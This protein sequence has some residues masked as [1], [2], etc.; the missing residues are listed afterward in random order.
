V[1]TTGIKEHAPEI[2]SA[3]CERLRWLGVVPGFP[4]GS[5]ISAPES[6]V[7]VHVIPTDEEAM[8]GQHT[9]GTIA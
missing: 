4:D 2:R 6:R 8:I 3:V 5:R 1:F 9:I 7:E